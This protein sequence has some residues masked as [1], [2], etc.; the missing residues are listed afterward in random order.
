LRPPGAHAQANPA[1]GP[2]TNPGTASSSANASTIAPDAAVITIDGICDNEPYSI[3]KPAAPSK[4]ADAGKPAAEANGGCKSVIT[5]ADFEYLV[6]VANPKVAPRDAIKFARFY[7]EQL[8]YAHKARALSLD[9]DPDFETILKFTSLQVLSRKISNRMMQDAGVPDAEIEKEIKEHPE[10]Y[11][12][13]DLLEIAI[14]KAKQHSDQTGSAPAK[15]DAVAEEV[16]MKAEA[17]KI[18]SR[19]AAGED[20]QSLQD[21]AYK[22]AGYNPDDSPDVEIGENTRDQVPE[23]FRKLVFDLQPGKVSELVSAEGYWH[24]FEVRSKQM[25]PVA[26]AK[27]IA[28]NQRFHDSMQALKAT[29]KPQFNDAYFTPPAAS[30]PAKPEVK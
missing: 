28:V 14:P 18:R 8:A 23:E 30:Q 25:M 17:E 19:A 26:R 16:E 13:V 24:L 21:E 27:A 20:F 7:S 15:V 11:E 29:V 6:K 2:A 5:R 1:S 4:V 10:K 12:Q 9:K 3:A 22:F